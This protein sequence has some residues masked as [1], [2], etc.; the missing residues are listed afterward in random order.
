[1]KDFLL[2]VAILGMYYFAVRYFTLKRQLEGKPSMAPELS[3]MLT[4]WIRS[5][6]SGLRDLGNRLSRVFKQGPTQQ[7]SSTQK[8]NSDSGAQ[9]SKGSWREFRKN[10]KAGT[11]GANAG[12]AGEGYSNGSAYKANGKMVVTCNHCSAKLNLPVNR[13]TLEVTCPKC[14]AVFQVFTGAKAEK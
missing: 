12:T 5:V 8:S 1:M 10:E 2:V 7:G 3:Q 6:K 4:N 14:K 11:T 13:G 9:S